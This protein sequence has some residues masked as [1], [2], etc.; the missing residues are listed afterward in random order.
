MAVIKSLEKTYVLKGVGEPEH[1]LGGDIEITPET[2][3]AL[4]AKTYLLS[5]VNKYLKSMR[6]VCIKNQRKNSIIRNS[7]NPISNGQ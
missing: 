7:M 3:V 2:K 1:Y 5:S 4:T 6:F